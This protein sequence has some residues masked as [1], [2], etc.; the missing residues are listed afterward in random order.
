LTSADWNTFNN[1]QN[2]LSN[3]DATTSGILTSTDWNTFNNK[4]N[5]LQNANATTSGILTNADW[6]T[7]NNKQNA[8]QNANATTSGI[9]TSTDWN[10]FNNKQ[11][12]LSN[13]NATTSGILT[14]TDWN[15]FNNK[16]SLPTLTSGSLLFSNGSTINQNNSKLYWDNINFRL[17]VGTSNLTFPLHVS[18]QGPPTDN[19][20][21]NTWI[22]A[23][24]GASSGSRLV[25]GTKDGNPTIGAKNESHIQWDTLDVNPGGMIRFPFYANTSSK[26]LSTNSTGIVKGLSVTNGLKIQND[27]LQLGGTLSN[28]TNINMNN[29][30][31]SF[32]SGGIPAV[33]TNIF[34]TGSYGAGYA[35]FGQSFRAETNGVLNAIRIKASTY[36]PN[37]INVT[38]EIF[39]SPDYSGPILYTGN[40]TV[41]PFGGNLEDTPIYELPININVVAGRV[42]TIRLNPNGN[43]IVILSTNSDVY[44]HGQ[45][46]MN[47]VSYP[48]DLRIQV[49]E[50]EPTYN[51][52][53]LDA[54][55]KNVALE[56]IVGLKINSIGGTGTRNV[57]V[58]PDGT[59]QAG[60]SNI[61]TVS[62][63]TTTAPLSVINAST[64]PQIAISQA[65]TSTNGFL[66]STDWNTFNNKQNVL[67]NASASASGILT[68][69]DWNTFNN[70]VA[71]S[72][73]IN[74][75]LPLIGG[76]NL[77]A[78]RTISIT[79][80]NSTTNGYLSSTDWNTFNNK[81]NLPNLTNGS[82]LFSNGSNISQS[83][84]NLFWDNTNKALGIGTTSPTAGLHIHG[85]NWDNGFRISSGTTVGPA[86]FLDGDTDFALI[87]TGT[88][89]G[90]GANKF[91]VYDATAN[92]YR[93]VIDNSGAMGVGIVNPSTKMDISG[94]GGLKVSSN[95]NNSGYS[96][97]VS[98]NFGG[99]TG[100]R[101]VVGIFN[102][103]PTIGGH[104]S[105]LNEW[106]N[107]ALNPIGGN[108]GI[109]TNAPTAKLDVVGTVRL[110]T[111]AT[112]NA[113]LVSDA[114]GNASW[115]SK[116]PLRTGSVAVTVPPTVSLGG[117]TTYGTAEV[118]WVHNLGYQPIIMISNEQTNNYS[119]MEYV[120]TSYYH[121]DNN[122][123]RIKCVN[124][125]GGMAEGTFRILIVN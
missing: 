23:S 70:K 5:A 67:G 10:T 25:L 13:A 26:L 55:N 74:T 39:D 73:T 60:S 75:A 45:L 85:Y 65:N 123:L 118:E 61:G 44:P 43:P 29:K 20:G 2:P 98:G 64:T 113:V 105:D 56:G 120:K 79:Q 12:P 111:G 30:D 34:T 95:Y 40:V 27:S 66:S 90:S 48:Y 28:K 57:V 69:A 58:T 3:A 88:S 122:T 49:V 51:L 38:Y 8:L 93:M 104:N 112:E 53:K 101:L 22:S 35:I 47:G 24:I 37:P 80:A 108:V 62:Q 109:G 102:Q 96:D 71:P 42:Y 84:S 15:T 119:L 6:N 86:V 99:Q 76:G 91:G 92:Q 52:L 106:R 82:I 116:T 117:T 33:T 125:A 1:K 83:N 110:R 121:V 46:F 19:G 32:M 14:S 114:N 18:S 9:L 7:F 36:P 78:D 41:S 54:A 81:Y 94:L 103:T 72:L 89:A 59:L 87:S 63:I 107:L 68:A 50:T 11:N 31:I 21:G 17:G 16:F 77:G 97:W 100:D 124:M 115:N 4:Q